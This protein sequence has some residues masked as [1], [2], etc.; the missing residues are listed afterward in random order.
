M[1][2]EKAAASP[3]IKKEEKQESLE[4]KVSASNSI[5]GEIKDFGRKALTIGAV[6]A[7]PFSF[8]Y[9]AP[10]H[11]T[12]AAVFTST[13]TAGRGT[14]NV[15]QNKPF[16]ENSLKHAAISLPVSYQLA[17][18][19]KG[20]DS[21]EA[22][23]TDNYGSLAGKSAKV[24]TWTTLGQPAVVT[25]RSILNYGLGRRFRENW[26]HHVKN[27]FYWLALP[28]S[29][30]VLAPISLFWK[31]TVSGCLS[32]VF[33]IMVASREGEGSIRNLYNAINPFSYASA[34]Y[35]L[36]TK[37]AR[38]TFSY[39]TSGMYSLGSGIREFFSSF[40]SKPKAKHGPETNPEPQ[41]EAN[42]HYQK[43]PSE[44][45]DKLVRFPSEKVKHKNPQY[46]NQYEKA[47]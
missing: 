10:D 24:A 36:G 4:E 30:N 15:M 46:Q 35:S 42:A 38:N 11:F 27:V 43:A 40:G 39:S 34:G 3:E 44:E 37:A 7:M 20:L 1:A 28:S 13:Y 6:A 8:N 14:A 17:E 21:L 32:Y 33:G 9:I 19:F 47:A 31:L 5:W 26:W 22:K 25:S 12:R 29:I 23:I 18:T 16:L 2:E 41:P 45:S